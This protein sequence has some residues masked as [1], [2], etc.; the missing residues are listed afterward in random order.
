MG[1]RSGSIFMGR[2]GNTECCWCVV[3]LKIIK[4]RGPSII[5]NKPFGGDRGAKRSLYL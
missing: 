3:E 5:L 2:Y 4:T 1:E